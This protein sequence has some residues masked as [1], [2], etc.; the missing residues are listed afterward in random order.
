MEVKI[1]L[2]SDAQRTELFGP[3]DVHLRFLRDALTVKVSARNG[4]VLVSG[5]AAAVRTAEDLIDRMQRRLLQ[6]GKLTDD[7]VDE[8]YQL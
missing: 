5:E 4:T 6:R 2:E 3:S 8:L 7:D 1:Q